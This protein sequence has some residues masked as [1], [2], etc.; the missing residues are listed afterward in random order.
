[1]TPVPNGQ[2]G[3]ATFVSSRGVLC[4]PVG[5][6]MYANVLRKVLAPALATVVGDEQFG[7]L[8]GRGTLC[9]L[10]RSRSWCN[11]ARADKLPLGLLFNDLQAAF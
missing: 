9:L 2:G 10:W 6:K 1:M 11:V 8:S 5:G 4:S 3:G 7:A